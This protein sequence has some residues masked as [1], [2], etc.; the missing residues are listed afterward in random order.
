MDDTET[1]E[2]E[3]AMLF[4]TPVFLVTLQL[5]IL[6]PASALDGLRVYSYTYLFFQVP[7]PLEVPP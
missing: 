4:D 3:V 6:H 2:E 1:V 7:F 5:L